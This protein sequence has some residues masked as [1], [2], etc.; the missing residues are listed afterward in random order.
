MI[1]RQK[2]ESQLFIYLFIYWKLSQ[3]QGILRD[4]KKLS[5]L[6]GYVAFPHVLAKISSI[7]SYF[8]R[9]VPFFFSGLYEKDAKQDSAIHIHQY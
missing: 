1:S 9:F 2:L 5:A 4:Q 8:Q 3:V 7:V 6:K